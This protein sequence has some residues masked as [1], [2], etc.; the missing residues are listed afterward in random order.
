MD[1]D[2]DRKLNLDLG[3]NGIVETATGRGLTGETIFGIEEENA[4]TGERETRGVLLPRT[5]RE[6]LEVW[7]GEGFPGLGRSVAEVVGEDVGM[8]AATAGG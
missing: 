1:R 4:L 8:I 5:F 3:L 6:I 2:L 7:F